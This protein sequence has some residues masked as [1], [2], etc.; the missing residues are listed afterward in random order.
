MEDCGVIQHILD[1]YSQAS[2]QTINFY[3]SS[4]VFSANVALEV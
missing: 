4:V 3:K 2:G 1:V